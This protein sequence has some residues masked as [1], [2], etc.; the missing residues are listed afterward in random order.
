MLKLRFKVLGQVRAI[1]GG[2]DLVE[3]CSIKITWAL[4]YHDAI[5]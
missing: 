4:A 2:V 5:S 3:G 1:R